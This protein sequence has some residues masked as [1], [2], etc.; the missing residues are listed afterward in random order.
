M[1]EYM[2]SFQDPQGHHLWASNFF[3]HH[4]WTVEHEFQSMK[5]LN[6]AEQMTIRH[7]DSPGK[8][9]RLGRSCTL[10]KDWEEVKDSAMWACLGQK[11]QYPEMLLPLLDSGDTILVEG[12]TWGD[13]YWGATPIAK[14]ED[15]R[16]L[17]EKHGDWIWDSGKGPVLYGRNMLGRQLMQLRTELLKVHRPT[18]LFDTV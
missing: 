7:A 12:N 3:W 13:R 9:K 14:S 15:I 10:R 17:I 4:G 6:F 16:T 11:F 5:T 18:T 1:Q 8:A 2:T